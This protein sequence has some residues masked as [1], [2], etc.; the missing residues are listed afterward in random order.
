M[1]TFRAPIGSSKPAASSSRAPEPQPTPVAS[2]QKNVRGGEGRPGSDGD[3]EDDDELLP[4][5]EGDADG[6][7]SYHG[8]DNSA[9]VRL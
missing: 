1:H 6:G 3:D 7:Y 4:H 9:S 2:S 5:P 8:S